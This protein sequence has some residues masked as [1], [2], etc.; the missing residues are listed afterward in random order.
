M[1]DILSSTNKDA[2]RAHRWRVPTP[3]QQLGLGEAG[4]DPSNVC[5]VDSLLGDGTLLTV[6]GYHVFDGRVRYQDAF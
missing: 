1:T 6:L 5:S 3:G 4:L 2:V